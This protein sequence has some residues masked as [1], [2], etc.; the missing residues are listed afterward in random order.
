M[1]VDG[2]GSCAP[3]THLRHTGMVAGPPFR[4]PLCG[5]GQDRE[6]AQEVRTAGGCATIQK[7]AGEA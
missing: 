2:P 5:P 7:R 4:D 1:Y 3:L 6:P